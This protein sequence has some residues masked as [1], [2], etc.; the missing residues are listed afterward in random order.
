[1]TVKPG[2][3][4]V[5]VGAALLIA[6]TGVVAAVQHHHARRAA[7]LVTTPAPPTSASTPVPSRPPVPPPQGVRLIW[8][9]V[10]TNNTMLEA[11]D[12][13]GTRRGALVLPRSLP[14]LGDITPSPDGQRL[15]VSMDGQYRLLSAQGA[16]LGLVPGASDNSSVSWSDDDRHLCEMV[17]D[18]DTASHLVLLTL[19]AKPRTITAMGWPPGNGGA[20]LAACSV[21][22][23]LAILSVSLGDDDAGH[24]VEYRVVRLSSGRTVRDV[25]PPAPNFSGA[26]LRPVP[27]ALGEVAA[28]A[29]GTRLALT[30]WTRMDA[31]RPVTT[32]VDT[33]SGRAVGSLHGG[34]IAFTA[35]DTAVELGS[36]QTDWRTGRVTTMPPRCCSGTPRSGGGD[37][38]IEIPTGP[39]PTPTSGV[40]GPPPP[41]IVALLHPDGSLVQLA[42]CGATVL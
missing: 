4:S 23:D 17:R 38:I 3:L 28:S 39:P 15:L 1:M 30:A 40:I 29:D 2:P 12:S 32:I 14:K 31:T 11:I 33:L 9:T 37:V 35:D 25:R 20:G 21:A 16:D 41:S 5:A 42:C 6:T 18:T 27:G 22:S 7:A 34:D 19:G 13:S 24:V 36:L 26:A 10:A 8:R